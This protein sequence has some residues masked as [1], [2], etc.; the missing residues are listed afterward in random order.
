MAKIHNHS[1]Q[2]DGAMHPV[3]GRGTT[4]VGSDEFE[5]TPRAMRCTA[6]D[7]DWFPSGQPDWHFR[8]AVRRQ[9]EKRAAQEAGKTLAEVA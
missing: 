1:E 9:E 4:A 8:S 6:C 3:C 2:F 5:A 7:R